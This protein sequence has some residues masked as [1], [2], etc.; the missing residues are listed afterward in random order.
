[1]KL[2]SPGSFSTFSPRPVHRAK[3]TIDEKGHIAAQFSAQVH[4]CSLGESQIKIGVE[5]H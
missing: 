3:G 4:Q 5:S 1:M 2:K